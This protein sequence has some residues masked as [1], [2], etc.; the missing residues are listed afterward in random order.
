MIKRKLKKSLTTI[1]KI[2]AVES[3]HSADLSSNSRCRIYILFML[4]T[5]TFSFVKKID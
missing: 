3:N 1:K 4:P 5:F 2:E